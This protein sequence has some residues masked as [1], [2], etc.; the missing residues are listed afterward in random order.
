MKVEMLF[1]G[2]TRFATLE[3]LVE[4]RQPITAYQIAM[5]KGIDPAATYRCLTELSNFKVVESKT[6]ERNQTFYKLSEGPGQA[7]AEFLRSLKQKT[8]QSV[9]LEEWI[10]PQMQAARMRQIVKLDKSDKSVFRDPDKKQDVD[11]IMTKRIAGEL[12]SLI[13]SAKIT[14][15]ELFEQKDGIFVLKI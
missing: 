3:A 12:S 8:P 7:A 13:T 6:G 15:N 9:D 10:S 1:G 11:E 2:T 5:T 4:A 14:F